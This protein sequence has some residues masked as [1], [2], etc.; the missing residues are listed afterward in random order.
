MSELSTSTCTNCETPVNE[1][2]C[3][4]CGQPAA[5]KRIDSHYVLHEVQHLLH[6][7][8]G[9][10][11][12]IKELLLRPGRNVREY[13]T[14]KRDKL[15]KPVVYII[16][17]SLVYSTIA[18]FFHIEKEIAGTATSATIGIFRWV[19]HHYGYANIIIGLFIALWLKLIFR[20]YHYN[21]FEIVVLLC[22]TMG[23]GM[24]IMAVFALAQ[25]VLHVSLMMAG[26]ILPFI[27]CA[28][29]IGQFFAGKKPL[30]YLLAF[31]AYMLGM[32]SFYL[33]VVFVGTMVDVLAK[34]MQA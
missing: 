14:K 23:T 18:H 2:F 16:I 25:G 9:L 6:V 3:G 13:L 7:E 15:V 17:T 4:H 5:L 21:F 26:S 33:V 20:K 31:V 11:Y 32:F 29:A 1:K 34:M 8:K 24:L 19:E 22:F 10:L 27:Y 12:T 30:G 28:W